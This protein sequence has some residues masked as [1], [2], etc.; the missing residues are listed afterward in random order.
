MNVLLVSNHATVI[1]GGEI[2]LLTLVAGLQQTEWR[3]TVV[4][5][6]PGEVADACRARAVEVHEIPLPTLRR[7]GFSTASAIRRF[8]RLIVDGGFSVVHCNGSRAMFY[9]GM[10]A[11][12]IGVPCVW[13]VRMLGPDPLLDAALV[14]LAAAS[15]SSSRAGLQRFERWPW[16]AERCRIIPN[17][18]DLEAFQ[19]ATTRAMTRSDLGVAEI[20]F[21]AAAVGRLVSWKAV[22]VL[23]DAA[24]LLAPQHP[25]LEV[26]IVGEGPEREAL[27]SRAAE[28]GVEG[29]VHFTG[30]RDDIADVLQAADV[31]AMT[32]TDEHFGRVVIE[33]MA[34]RLP[35]VAADFGGP[36]EIVLDGT[37]GLLVAPGDA[38][39]LAAAIDR[40][41]GDP[42]ERRRMGEEGRRRV[43]ECYSSD[44]HVEGVIGVYEQLVSRHPAA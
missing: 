26:L 28:R 5:P 34:M 42:D 13:H 20:S 29:I 23:I 9:A 18:I 43:E 31:F 40:L 2:S 15:I 21:V 10:A 41:A 32:S 7:P 30:H 36:A 22:E 25:D 11:R 17:G 33:A 19:P 35:V 12:K 24:E 1:G 16:A 3:P 44:R 39:A 8:R 6:G 38:R 14:R 27:Q 37:T 4:V